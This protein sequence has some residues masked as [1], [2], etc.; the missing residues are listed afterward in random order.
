[1]VKSTVK[2]GTYSK[3]ITIDNAQFLRPISLIT[4]QRRYP[5]VID[6]QFVLMKNLFNEYARHYFSNNFARRSHGPN[7]FQYGRAVKTKASETSSAGDS[8]PHQRYAT[9][10][11]YDSLQIKDGDIYVRNRKN[12]G[13]GHGWAGA[14]MVVWNSEAKILIIHNPPGSL[15]WM[16]GSKGEL[17]NDKKINDTYTPKSLLSD[18]VFGERQTQGIIDPSPA[19]GAIGAKKQL[20]S[21]IN[22]L[23]KDNPTNSLYEAQK[24]ES[25]NSSGEVKR[26]VYSITSSN[27]HNHF[28]FSLAA[29]EK[30]IAAYLV[31]SCLSKENLNISFGPKFENTISL[32]RSNPQSRQQTQPMANIYPI[33]DR[34]LTDL[35]VSKEI[36]LSLQDKGFRW[37]ELEIMV[38]ES[39]TN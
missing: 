9:G 11:L 10:T 5:F 36:K 17:R 14:G 2:A 23:K 35:N 30:V 16:I 31:T 28:Q 27:K 8:G 32:S 34:Y 4:G 25:K 13:S 39:A 3:N 21:S 29:S 22:F 20:S 38:L 12:S 1:M 19:V 33:A 7:V 26:R 37:A 24:N 15:N 18:P 6:G